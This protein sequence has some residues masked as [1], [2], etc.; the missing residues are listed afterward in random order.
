MKIII[1]DDQAVVLDELEILLTL[2]KDTDV[3]GTAQEGT[4]AV[5]LVFKDQPELILMDLK[6]PGMNVFEAIRGTVR[7]HISTILDKLGV[8]NRTQV[9][10]IAIQQRLGN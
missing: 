8:S 3:I 2:E 9:A 7:N 1:S 4:E 5:E 10:V 6:M